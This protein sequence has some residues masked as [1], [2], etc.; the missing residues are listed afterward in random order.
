MSRKF[1]PLTA[2]TLEHTT[3]P[4]PACHEPFVVG[5]YTTLVAIGPGKSEEA[6]ERCR[7]GRAYNAI[8]VMAHYGCVTGEE[9]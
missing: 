5:D 8:A 3:S 4:C 6:R 1:G 2:E 7:D 9:T